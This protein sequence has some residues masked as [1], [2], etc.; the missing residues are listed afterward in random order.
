MIIVTRLVLA[1]PFVDVDYIGI[2]ELSRHLP[3]PSFQVN[4]N[5]SANFCIMIAPPA[6]YTSAWIASGPDAFLWLS[7]FFFCRQ[8]IKVLFDL[9]SWL[10]HR[11]QQGG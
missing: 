7:D 11:F 8:L 10:L 6:L 4:W 2:F 1:L 9:H 3:F 5:S